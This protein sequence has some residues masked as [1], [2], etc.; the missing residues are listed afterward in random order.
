MISHFYISAM[1]FVIGILYAFFSEQIIGMFKKPEEIASDQTIAEPKTERVIVTFKDATY[2]ITD[3]VRKHPG[4]KEVLLENNGKD[5]E[6]LMLD[7]GHS[8]HA[9]K[10]L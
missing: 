3:F 9:Y 4:G 10:T 5:I 6:K 8:E 2:D 7:I 1:V